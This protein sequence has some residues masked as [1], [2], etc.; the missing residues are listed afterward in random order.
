MTIGGL[1]HIFRLT[2]QQSISQR[3]VFLILK[4]R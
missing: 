4:F 3:V 1:S 2:K